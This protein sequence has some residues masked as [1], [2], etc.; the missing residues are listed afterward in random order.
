MAAIMGGRAFPEVECS[1]KKDGKTEAADVALRILMGEGQLQPQAK[2]Q[3]EVSPSISD[4]LKIRLEL[5]Y[6]HGPVH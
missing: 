6:L 4:K 2:S 5:V 1:N 3:A